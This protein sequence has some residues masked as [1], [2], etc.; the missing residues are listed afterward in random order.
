MPRI[1]GKSEEKEK[2]QKKKRRTEQCTRGDNTTKT[3]LCII[4]T[5]RAF[6]RAR[7]EDLNELNT[8]TQNISNM[9]L[10]REKAKIK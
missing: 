9:Q 8:Q 6:K 3:K 5:K 2:K 4:K 1:G 7:W 10:I